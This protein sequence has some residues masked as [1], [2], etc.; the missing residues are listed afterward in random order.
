MLWLPTR[1]WVRSAGLLT[2]LPGLPTARRFLA[3]ARLPWVR[4]VIRLPRPTSMPGRLRTRLWLVLPS[5]LGAVLF[6]LTIRALRA[7]LRTRPIRHWIRIHRLVSRSL[8]MRA[9]SVLLL[10][11]V[12]LL[13]IRLR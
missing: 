7:R 10:L 6:L 5:F 11:L 9:G 4:L 3:P 8:P 13:S 1:R 12:R 2:V